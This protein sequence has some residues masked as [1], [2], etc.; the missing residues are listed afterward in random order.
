MRLR[1]FSK[2][3]TDKKRI[4]DKEYEMLG[5]RWNLVAGVWML[6]VMALPVC[7]RAAEAVDTGI[8]PGAEAAVNAAV[9]GYR[10]GAGDVLSISVW[11]NADLTKVVQ[12][13]PDGNISFPLIG[14]IMVSEMTVAQ[15]TKTLQEKI[16]PFAPEPQI[17]V[18]VQQVNSLVVYVIGRTNHAGRF[19]L[20][21]NINVLQG[22]AM[23]GGLT[24][25]A[26]RADIKVFRTEK[27]GTKVYPFDYDA[28]TERNALAQNIQLKRGDIIVVP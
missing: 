9:E 7:G 27:E 17:S 16:A 1:K 20:N 14:Q 4:G 24:P 19:A 8:S 12:V 25:F 26:K 23:A 2:D 28:V 21:G 6:A 3:S 5:K 11:K 22:L 10:I 15:L 13:L 18:E